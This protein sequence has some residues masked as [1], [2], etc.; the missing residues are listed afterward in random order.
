[1]SEK[2]CNEDFRLMGSDFQRRVVQHYELGEPSGRGIRGGRRGP[3]LS[4]IYGWSIGVLGKWARSLE[5]GRPKFRRNR[6]HEARM[7]TKLLRLAPFDAKTRLR[8]VRC[9]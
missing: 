3:A 5:G 8:L 9:W 6:P 4:N 2:R 7:C 1:M